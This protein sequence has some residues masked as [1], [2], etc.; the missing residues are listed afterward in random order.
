MKL[1]LLVCISYSLYTHVLRMSQ[2]NRELEELLQSH[3]FETTHMNHFNTIAIRHLSIYDEVECVDYIDV[4]SNLCYK[5]LGDFKYH[6]YVNLKFGTK[7]NILM[8][9]SSY[10][11]TDYRAELLSNIL[12][13]FIEDD[14]E[15]LDELNKFNSNRSN[16]K[17]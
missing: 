1:R 13:R 16:I 17:G 5:E 12:V 11:L 7:H 10:N 9:D 3:Q 4:R 15:L 2:R 14:D 8:T 6:L